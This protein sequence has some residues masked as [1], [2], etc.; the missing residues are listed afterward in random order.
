MDNHAYCVLPLTAVSDFDGIIYHSR[1]FS[2]DIVSGTAYTVHVLSDQ[3]TKALPVNAAKPN[4]RILD[5]PIFV[6]V[7][8][9]VDGITF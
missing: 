9:L 1:R 6:E 3:E 5:K 7:M 8:I 4:K 2:Y